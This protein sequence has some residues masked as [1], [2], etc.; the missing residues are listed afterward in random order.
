[1]I[2]VPI[3]WELLVSME[4]VLRFFFYEDHPKYYDIIP[5]CEAC[6]FYKGCSDCVFASDDGKCNIDNMLYSS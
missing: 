2:N 4:V 1:M 6:W 5:T 3:M